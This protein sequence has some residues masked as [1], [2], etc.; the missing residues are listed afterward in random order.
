[1]RSGASRTPWHGQMNSAR[2]DQFCWQFSTSVLPLTS[3]INKQ[4]DF[5]ERCRV[6]ESRYWTVA[7]RPHYCARFGEGATSPHRSHALVATLPG[8]YLAGT[9]FFWHVV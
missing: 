3:S 8:H 2:A 6:S 4:D 1:M 7:A 5:Y 9:A